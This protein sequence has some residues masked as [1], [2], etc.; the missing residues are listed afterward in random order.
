MQRGVYEIRGDSP[1]TSERGSS[2][3]REGSSGSDHI[4]RSFMDLADK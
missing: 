3:D 1:F 2:I 4:F